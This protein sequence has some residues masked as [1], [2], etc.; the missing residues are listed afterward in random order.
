MWFDFSRQWLGGRKHRAV[1][2]R[3]GRRVIG[4]ES[5]RPALEGLESRWCPSLT[6]TPAGRAAG[7]VLS[8]FAVDFPNGSCG[9]SC[10]NAGPLGVAFP[11]SGGVLVSDFP[12]N[13]RLFPTDT[14]GQ[15]ADSFAPGQN[16]GQGN[17]GD[18]ALLRGN[19]YMG[20][21]TLGRIVQ[22]HSDGTLDHV[23]ASGL[24]HVTGMQANPVTGR[25]FLS[26]TDANEIVDLDPSN[27]QNPPVFVNVGGDIDGLTLSADGRTLYVAQNMAGHIL[28]FDTITKQQVF[29]SGSIAGNPDGVAIGVGSLA[30]KLFV[31][32]NG[33]AVVEVDI[34]TH[35]Q[36]VI[37]SGGS[38]GDYV[39]IDPRDGSALFTQTD[40]II[41][42]TF[43]FGAAQRLTVGGFPSPSIAGTLGSVTVT[44]LD[45]NGQLATGYTGTVHFTSSD[46]QATLPANYT[47]TAADRGT[48]TF[49]GVTLKTAGSQT[50]TVTDTSDPRLTGTQAGIVVTPAATSMLS[51][52]FAAITRAGEPRALMVTA[53]DQYGNTTSAYTGTVHLASSDGQ[54]VVEDDH[55]FTAADHGTYAF[56]VVLV[57]AGPQT[58]TAT[59]I[60]SGI[61]S[62]ANIA[63]TPAPAVAFAL[64][65]PAS[66]P[67]G[68]P[69]D[70]TVTAVD[71]YGNTDTNYQGTITFSTTDPD[72]GVV[73]PPDY[74]FQ[75]SDAG[76]VTF[77]GGV[78]LITPGDQILTATD[79]ADST[80]TGSA[81]VT[82]SSGN[83]PLARWAVANPAPL[84][85]VL[86]SP[87][88]V[89]P[90]DR[91]ESAR[92]EAAAA[93]RVFASLHQDDA[94][95]FPVSRMPHDR[96]EMDA[97]L[98]DLF[99][100]E[101]LRLV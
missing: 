98:P 22:I 3:S 92:S 56:G 1:L 61:S 39:R 20:Q 10:G 30:G 17:T 18:L 8:E 69:F 78:T 31:N 82:V 87:V 96:H 57:T 63:V 25:L 2:P 94:A 32:T 90:F 81:T 53:Q 84:G 77:P 80:I 36:T 38:R 76:M 73:L 47:F 86:A 52:A 59:D 58:I 13:V 5:F 97:R 68:T 7:I 71:P 93:D 51:V 23:V 101:D 44:A 19:I 75:P 42:L 72:P 50:I 99:G 74:T 91:S 85:T 28:G 41:R 15:S 64:T 49:T 11:Q 27:P 37:A 16:Y 26:V 55:T 12:G 43:P 45:Q 9:S 35:Q 89:P 54:A 67:S 60:D 62:T 95:E 100:R 29:D 48:H 21:T 14:D 65:A 33:G 46:G 40:R 79:T 24:P 88:Q 34:A 66:V 4:W 83:A 70:V 6:L